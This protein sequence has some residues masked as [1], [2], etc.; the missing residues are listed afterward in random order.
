MSSRVLDKPHALRHPLR[1]VVFDFLKRAILRQDRANVH[2]L[3]RENARRQLRALRELSTT[4]MG[5]HRTSRGENLTFDGSGPGGEFG[6]V[7]SFL[8]KRDT[9]LRRMIPAEPCKIVNLSVGSNAGGPLTA[10][11]R[12]R[13]G[14]RWTFAVALVMHVN[15]QPEHCPNCDA[16]PAEDRGAAPACSECNARAG[17]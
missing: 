16:R 1:F 4:R 14:L 10:K 13:D 15:F 3:S 7:A 12:S 6:R 11:R 5:A 8:R 2:G 17:P 9:A